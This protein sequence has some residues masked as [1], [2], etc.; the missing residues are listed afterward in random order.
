MSRER[1]AI[2]AD[3]YDGQRVQGLDM[4]FSINLLWAMLGFLVGTALFAALAFG[5]DQAL[6][7][8]VQD[9]ALSR[10]DVR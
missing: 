7:S 1:I 4:R 8:P 2:K 5:Q 9:E 10:P 3:A 6:R